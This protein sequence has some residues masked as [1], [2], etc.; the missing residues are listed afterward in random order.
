MIW[1]ECVQKNIKWDVPSGA[2]GKNPPANAGNMGLIPGLGR[3]HMPWSNEAPVSQLLKPSC[4]EPVLR[5]KRTPQTT[6]KSS[7]R[8]PQ[9]EK[10]LASN[11]DLVQP[12]IIL[13]KKVNIAS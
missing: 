11:E 8:S 12:K 4:L 5:N 2:V 1:R 13:K 10:A 7:S 9:L 3:V 6:T